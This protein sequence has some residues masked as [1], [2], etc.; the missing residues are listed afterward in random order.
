MRLEIGF[1]ASH[2]GTDMKAI[3]EAT[4]SGKLQ[5]HPK[6][7]ISNNKSSPALD[8]AR[9]HNIPATHI[10]DKTHKDPDT[11]IRD[12]LSLHKVNLVVMS[13]Y[14]KKVEKETRAR[15][16]NRILN[17]H[18]ALLPKYG[19]IYGDAVHEA[20]LASND[21]YTGPT[22]HLIDANYDTGQIIAQ[23]KVKIEPNDSISSLKK[24][25]QEAEITL[26][27]KV[28]GDLASERLNL[29]KL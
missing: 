20:V 25:V 29:D 14:M 3:I 13:G 15:F 16:K 27:L 28:L 22:I 2:N 9:E 4:E 6:I 24:R 18:P 11:A 1:L 19:A 23:S 17:V 26:Y 7:V 8:Y 12:A 5:A 10:N 21:E